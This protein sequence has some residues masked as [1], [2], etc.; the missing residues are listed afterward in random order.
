MPTA[1]SWKE[2]GN[3]CG[4]KH[5]SLVCQVAF[6]EAKEESVALFDLGK[7]CDPCSEM[8]LCRK[9]WDFCKHCF[10]RELSLNKQ[11]GGTEI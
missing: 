11:L 5:N 6:R 2:K 4:A 8:Q 1:P 7:L 3:Q 10:I 9:F